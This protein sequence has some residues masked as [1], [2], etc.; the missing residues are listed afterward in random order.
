MKV[1]C[2]G[3]APSVGCLRWRY[4]LR[5]LSG[6]S[7]TSSPLFP[8]SVVT[9]SRSASDPS[10]HTTASGLVSAATSSTQRLTA[11]LIAMDGESSASDRP[12]REHQV[13]LRAAP[14]EVELQLA[15]PAQ[16]VGRVDAQLAEIVVAEE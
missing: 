11:S 14:G 1:R 4:E 8:A 16:L 6:L 5:S 3:R 13:H 9:P 12:E 15:A 7:W 2:S 10:H